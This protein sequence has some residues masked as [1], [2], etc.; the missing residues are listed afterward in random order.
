MT[1]SIITPHQIEGKTQGGAGVISVSTKTVEKDP[2]DAMLACN[3][4]ALGRQNPDTRS[5]N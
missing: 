2:P 4:R 5:T 3:H 1:N